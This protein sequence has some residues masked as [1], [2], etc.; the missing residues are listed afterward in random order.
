MVGTTAMLSGSFHAPLFAALIVFEM[1]GAYE[2]LVPLM[3]AAAIGYGLSAPFQPGSVYTFAF[4]KLGIDLR[5]GRF[6]VAPTAPPDGADR[7]A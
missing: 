7:K 1:A 6:R 2:M 3:L 4:G 5:P